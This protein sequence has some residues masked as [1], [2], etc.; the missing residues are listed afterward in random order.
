MQTLL[1]ILSFILTIAFFMGTGAGIG[2]LTRGEMSWYDPLIKSV[3]NP[4]GWVFGVVWATLYA[5]IAISFWLLWQHRRHTQARHAQ[6][7]FWIQMGLNWAWS[8]VFFTF[9]LKLL[10]FLWIVVLVGA[11]LQTIRALWPISR[12]GALLLTPYLAWISFASYLSAC[13]WWLNP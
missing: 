8:F 3:L 10:A 13:I 7:W 2:A 4:P 12:P 9:H 6:K 11:V 1:K 5:L